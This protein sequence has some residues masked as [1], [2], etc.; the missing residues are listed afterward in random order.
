EEYHHFWI[1]EAVYQPGKLFGLVLD[2]VKVEPDR[3]LVQVDARSEVGGG[4]NILNL[5]GQ[6]LGDVDLQSPEQVSKDLEPFREALDTFCPGEYHLSRPEDQRRNLGIL[7]PDDNAREPL[8]I[9][10]CILDLGGQCWQIKVICHLC[11]GDNI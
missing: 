5:V 10:L 3:N 7:H 6:L 11:R 2:P 9:V 1:L 4:D 8:F